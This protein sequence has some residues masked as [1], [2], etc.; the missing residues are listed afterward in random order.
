MEEL[1]IVGRANNYRVSSTELF[2]YIYVLLS[3]LRTILSSYSIKLTVRGTTPSCQLP[4]NW[5]REIE[6][7][8][9]RNSSPVSVPFSFYFSS[10]I[11][12]LADTTSTPFFS[13]ENRSGL[14][15]M[16]ALSRVISSSSAGNEIREILRINLEVTD[17]RHR[18]KKSENSFLFEKPW[19]SVREF[20]VEVVFK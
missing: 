13:L 16:E 18:M 19:L 1:S 17:L 12:N 8:M 14:W 20:S 11:G 4:E 2:A 15:Q 6:C 3:G 10:G 7:D 5:P 9:P